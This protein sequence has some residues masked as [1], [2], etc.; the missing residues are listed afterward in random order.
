M[1]KMN[2]E[3]MYLKMTLLLHMNV[4]IHH[5]SNQL[6]QPEEFSVS[7]FGWLPK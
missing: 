4:F 7:P 2:T 5:P 3:V 6:I 1:L